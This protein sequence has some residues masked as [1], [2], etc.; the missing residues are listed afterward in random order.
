MSSQVHEFTSSLVH[1]F[2]SS[3]VHEN[4]WLQLKGLKIFCPGKKREN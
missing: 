4:L 3:R 2:T 1:E